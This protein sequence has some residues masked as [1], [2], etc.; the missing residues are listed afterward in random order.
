M[1]GG[2]S[3]L[4]GHLL[5]VGEVVE[6]VCRL[7]DLADRPTVLARVGDNAL[8]L[9]ELMVVDGFDCPEDSRDVLTDG[10]GVLVG[11]VHQSRLLDLTFQSPRSDLT[12]D[13]LSNDP[14]VFQEL[15][16]D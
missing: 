14:H 9:R 1:L 2:E 15:S 12:V 6:V 13:Q 5:V 8:Q 7:L 11:L 3:D 4:E 10:R 16:V